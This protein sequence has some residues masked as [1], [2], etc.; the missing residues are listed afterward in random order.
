M[1][2]PAPMTAQRTAVASHQILKV[3]FLLRVC[4][5]CEVEFLVGPGD[6]LYGDRWYH[7]RCWVTLQAAASEASKKV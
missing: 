6:V 3:N 2:L 7:A 4:R 1:S 5:Y